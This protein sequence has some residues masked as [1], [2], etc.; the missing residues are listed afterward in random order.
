VVVATCGLGGVTAG[1]SSDDEVET[2]S[3]GACLEA[4]GVGAGR[5]SRKLCGGATLGRASMAL[6]PECR[7]KCVQW[8]SFIGRK[9]SRLSYWRRRRRCLRASFSPLGA[10]SRMIITVVRV[11]W[12]KTLSVLDER[13]RRLRRRHL[14]GGVAFRD[15]SRPAALL[16]SPRSWVASAGGAARRLVLVDGS[17]GVADPSWR[18]PTYAGGQRSSHGCRFWLLAADRDG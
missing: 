2:A 1:A 8:M 11:L 17:K 13:R 3:A 15:P 16:V 4:V 18:W 9:P 10:S 7:A 5:G 12:V 6:A 14:L